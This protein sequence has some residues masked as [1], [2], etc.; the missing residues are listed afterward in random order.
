MKTRRNND[1]L[2]IFLSLTLLVNT[3]AVIAKE[4]T[5]NEEKITRVCNGE[6]KNAADVE[7]A[8]AKCDPTELDKITRICSG[9]IRDLAEAELA[10][11]K[12]DS[13]AL[14]RLYVAIDER[15]K[16]AEDLKGQ[17]TKIEKE[18][19]VKGAEW[20]QTTEFFGMF[21]LPAATFAVVA[22]AGGLGSKAYVAAMKK[23]SI[24]GSTL[25]SKFQKFSSATADIAITESTMFLTGGL[26]Y[27]A[28]FYELEKR[29]N[30]IKIRVNK[31]DM[32]PLKARILEI[33]AE[34]KHRKM[35]I[36]YL[37]KAKN[38]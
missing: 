25:S 36:A 19:Y 8:K 18:Y 11:A 13:S 5:P 21:A 4:T 33:Q 20:L 6:I 3:C 27:F 15:N 17:I 22:G 23:Y 35:V 24:G 16:E 31:E 26:L 32:A 2:K 37:L 10:K 12:C 7:I 9:E 14:N 1:F 34:L 29:I 38:N 30:V 28:A